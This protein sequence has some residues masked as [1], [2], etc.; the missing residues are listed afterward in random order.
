MNDH[1]DRTPRRAGHHPRAWTVILITALVLLAADL[2]SKTLAFQHV[3]GEAVPLGR[4]AS[5]RLP[6]V[7]AHE[8]VPL[9]PGILSLHLTANE[10]AVFGLGQGGRWIF[11]CLSVAAIGVIGLV[12]WRS[13][14]GAVLL[15][16]ALGA[17]LAGALGNLYD[18]VRF[19]AVRDM[20]WLFPGVKLPFG[21]RWP[22]G[23]DDLYPWIFNIADVALLIGVGLLALIMLRGE[24]HAETEPALGGEGA[25]P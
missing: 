8:P 2:A 7:P 16:L 4:D 20:L 15:H 19:A 25:G 23:S 24:R 9:V 22:G 12:F 10:G 1:V 11:I 13:R 18:R 17:V 5:G 6:A 14:P 21:W 3:A